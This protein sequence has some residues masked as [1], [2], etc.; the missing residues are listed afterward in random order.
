MI[1][2]LIDLQVNY[3]K[4]ALLVGFFSI[5]F[6]VEQMYFVPRFDSLTITHTFEG[7]FLQNFQ[8]EAPLVKCGS[9]MY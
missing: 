1:Q 6:R 9:F 3:F 8:L 2:D 4:V 7:V 5:N